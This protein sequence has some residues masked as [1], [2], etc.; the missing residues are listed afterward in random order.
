[1]NRDQY[2]TKQKQFNK[3]PTKPDGRNSTLPGCQFVA[4][5][6]PGNSQAPC[7][8]P[9]DGTDKAHKMLNDK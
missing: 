3:N 4:G 7:S 9:S 6:S 8:V 2:L 1:M 5:G